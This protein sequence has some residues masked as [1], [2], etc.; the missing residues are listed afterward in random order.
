MDV[1][2]GSIRF[3]HVSFA[4]ASKEDK[5]VLDGIDLDIL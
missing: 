5:K 3:S 1:K 4:Y 2:D